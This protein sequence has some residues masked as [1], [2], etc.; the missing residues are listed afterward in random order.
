MKIYR[1]GSP[2]G[3]GADPNEPLDPKDKQNIGKG[4]RLDPRKTFL[5]K[6][7][8]RTPI[9]YQQFSP[10]KIS[11]CEGSVLN[12]RSKKLSVIPISST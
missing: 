6:L 4:E 11:I 12:I 7:H 9:L 10:Y 8:K 5:H 1:P 2:F 3:D